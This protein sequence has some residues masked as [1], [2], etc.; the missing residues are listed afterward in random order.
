VPG[1]GGAL[2][3][4]DLHRFLRA[5]ALRQRLDSRRDVVALALA[6]SFTGNRE[7]ARSALEFFGREPSVTP[8]MG[9]AWFLIDLLLLDGE[10]LVAADGTLTQH[11]KSKGTKVPQHTSDEMVTGL[12][13]SLVV[14]MDTTV[15]S[16]VRWVAAGLRRDEWHSSAALTG[17]LS[18]L[19]K[20]VRLPGRGDVERHPMRV[21]VPPQPTP[22]PSAL[23]AEPEPD[24][25]EVEPVVPDGMS[26][27]AMDE[28]LARLRQAVVG[29]IWEDDISFRTLLQNPGRQ[30]MVLAR[31]EMR[32]AS[33]E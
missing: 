26:G 32:R 12:V 23:T 22:V 25:V 30:E 18:A 14:A 24:V 3:R 20:V 1:D 10:A 13:A 15:Q 9:L 5:P 19:A 6:G 16:W 28:Y 7:V 8:E 31:Y 29:T 27:T 4:A 33:S 21:S 17:L 2:A 11:L